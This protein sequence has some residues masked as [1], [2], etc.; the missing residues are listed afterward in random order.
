[1]ADQS[2]MSGVAP[3]GNLR[4]QVIFWVFI[5]AS[6]SY[7]DRI[8]LS[9]AAPTITKAFNLSKS[10]MGLVFSAFALFYALSQP[11][12]G[13][14]ADRVGPYKLIAF[15]IVWWGV[16]TALTPMV[17]PG[18]PHALALLITVRCLL[19]LG[20]AIIFPASNR[21]VSTWIPTQERGLAN[22]LIFAGVGIG[23]GIAPPLISYI[24]AKAGWEWAFYASALIGVAAGVIWLIVVRNRP[25][26]H[27]GISKEEAEYI[28]AGLPKTSADTAPR[29]RWSVLLRDGQV[30]LLTFSYF[31]FGYVAYIFFTWFY[32]YLKEN[33]GL[34]LKA[35]ALYAALPFIAITVFS[36][37][38]GVL[39]DWLCK[40]TNKRLGR[41]GVAGIGM[42]LAA[43][44]VAVATQVADAKLA[45]LILT[46]GAGALYLA[47]SAFWALSA[48][49]GG[50]SAGSVSGLMN[51]GPGLG[52]VL[53]A[54]TTAKIAEYSWT[55]SFL[56]AAAVC[57]AG[58][59]AWLFI[60]P[61][62]ELRIRD[63][64]SGK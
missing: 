15:A 12:A 25:S 18:I 16:F 47:Q 62:H 11:F 52:G 36:T 7:L 9:V 21:L 46:G 34:D 20:E 17:P 58:A 35:S 19:G 57:L 48:D 2:S 3:K 49:I 43:I 22:G 60:N 10:E 5:I 29:V 54:Y 4:W 63:E 64:A 1:M 41:C 37:F 24:I 32:T 45:A 31:C 30:W 6:I 56:V 42:L 28:E 53:T 14:I 55:A 26:E 44:F 39:S 8:N 23:G 51:V 59:I 38:G 33:R 27:S 40:R 13:R 61:H 50:K